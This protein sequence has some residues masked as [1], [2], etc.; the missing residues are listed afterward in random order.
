MNI[1]NIKPDRR[2]AIALLKRELP[3]FVYDAVQLEGINFTLPEVQTLMD[4]VTVGGHKLSDQ[5]IALNQAAAWKQLII[6]IDVDA[7]EVTAKYAKRLHSIA[8]RNE[9]LEWGVFRSGAVTIAGTDYMPPQAASLEERFKTL[10]VEVL[11]TAIIYEKAI[12]CFLNMAR[13]QY[14]PQTE[15]YDVNKRMGRF[16][17]NGILLQAGYPA[18]N[19]K[20][21]RQLEFN[22]RMLQFYETGEELPMQE[23]LISCLDQKYIA[24]MSG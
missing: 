10:E 11:N 7:F 12:H 4:G 21:S 16:I 20:A 9:A 14:F 15:S 5:E 8:G 13:T 23:F 22:E 3:V 17:M 6:D 1:S 2:K 18:I 19:V 24:V